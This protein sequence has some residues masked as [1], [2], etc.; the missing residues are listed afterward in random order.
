[1][2]QKKESLSYTDPEEKAPR[3]NGSI[4]APIKKSPLTVQ[5][6][7]A[8][9]KD[10]ETFGPSEKQK[11][12]EQSWLKTLFPYPSKGGG[13][14]HEQ[15]CGIAG[16]KPQKDAWRR[17]STDPKGRRPTIKPEIAKHALLRKGGFG[18]KIGRAGESRKWSA[19]AKTDAI[20]RWRNAFNA[21]FGTL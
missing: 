13:G 8:H 20:C 5:N 4:G 17:T 16:N 21:D 14:K 19:E 15:A 7:Q 18:N 2:E 12:Q 3:I 10:L 1:M 9:T 6:P 11:G